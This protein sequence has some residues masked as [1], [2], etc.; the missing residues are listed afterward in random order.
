MDITWISHGYHMGITRVSHGYHT[1]ITW[2][3]HGYHM[4]ITRYTFLT[5]V[6]KV[7]VSTIC[8]YFLF[9]CER[10]VEAVL[11]ENADLLAHAGL[12]L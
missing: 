10:L 3:S 2:V 12:A 4:G 7:V 11:T 9:W 1:G 6:I 5:W 8:Q